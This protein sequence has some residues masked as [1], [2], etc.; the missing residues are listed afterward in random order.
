M[1]KVLRLNNLRKPVC[2]ATPLVAL[3]CVLLASS[4]N[5][6]GPAEAAPSSRVK[7]LVTDLAAAGVEERVSSAVTR[8]I[9]TEIARR[10]AF[11]VISG[12]DLR[13][14]V[15]LEAEREAV[16]CTNDASCLA[17][18]AGALGAQ[19]VVFGDVT[20]LGSALIVSLTLLDSQSAS[21]IG[22]SSQK[23]AGE[24]GLPTAVPVLVAELFGDNVDAALA[25]QPS[26]EGPPLLTYGTLGVGAAALVVGVIALGIGLYPLVQH[27]IAKGEAEALEA[28]GGIEDV[29]R[30]K[31]LYATQEE[32]NAQWQ[33][34]GVYAL[35]A[36]AGA[37]L[38]GLALSGVGGALLAFDDGGAE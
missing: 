8:L 1:V 21:A 13:R 17:E 24:D 23:V 7:L 4:S 38:V 25:E 18:V 9:A 31:S 22:R 34:Y 15:E 29:D 35:G 36:S 37:T 33:G 5:A 3:V 16:G 2:F 27:A 12:E 14:M 30:A 11:D 26:A 19:R 6:Q 20:R 28:E 32:F 10:D